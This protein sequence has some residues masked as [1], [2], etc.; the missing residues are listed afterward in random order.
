MNNNSEEKDIPCGIYQHYTGFYA[1]VLFLAWEKEDKEYRVIY[2][3]LEPHEGP[4]IR[5]RKLSI[6]KEHVVVDGVIMPRF[7]Y[8]GTK[9]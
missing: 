5:S 9:L 1:Q 6:F 3:P 2:V 8:I 7:T 4:R